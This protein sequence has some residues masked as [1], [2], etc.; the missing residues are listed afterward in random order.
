MEISPAVE[1]SRKRAMLTAY[2]EHGKINMAAYVAGIS[3]TSHRNWLKKDEDYA[4]AW[5]MAKDTHAAKR[6]TVLEHLETGLVDRLS[7][8]IE[9]EVW[10]EGEVVGT[11]RKY[12]DAV[13]L[14]LLTALDDRYAA[15][16]GGS[17]VNVNVD[18]V[19]V[20]AGS[21]LERFTE[22]LDALVP[23]PEVIDAE[24]VE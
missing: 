15:A 16:R 10:F 8:G 13:A 24:V 9:E 4:E 19:N 6:E 11:K 12:N 3:T 17:S 23:A 21:V 18:V 5:E 14:K 22:K 20:D 7:N 1:D 2:V